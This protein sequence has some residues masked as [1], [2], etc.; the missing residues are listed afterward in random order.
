MRVLHCIPSMQRGGAQRQ[1]TYIA[2]ELV[3]VG[4]D[5]HV[6]VASD[7]P[8]LARLEAT[9][10][11]VHRLASSNH[12][13]P[14]L[15]ARLSRIVRRVRPD[16]IQVWLRQMEA[17]GGVVALANGTPFIFSERSSAGAYP[18]TLKNTVRKSMARWASAIV[19]NSAG[20]DRYWEDHAGGRVRRYTIANAVP[21][22]EIAAA[23]RADL[24]GL[25]IGPGQEVVLFA[26]R[27]EREKNLETLVAALKRVLATR[28]A[29]AVCCGEGRLR[30]RLA[31]W[32]REHDLASRVS[33]VGYVPDLWSWMKRANV[34]VSPS[35]FEGNPNVVLEAM[36]CGSPLVVSDIPAHRELVDETTALLV[37]ASSPES[38]A[39]AINRALGAPAAAAERAR[40]AHT[41]ASRCAL[42]VMTRQY[43]EMYREVLASATPARGLSSLWARRGWSLKR[44]GV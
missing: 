6:A 9:G 25:G 38:L 16:L 15:I 17:L 18:R 10:A 20:G 34:V 8:N 12:H 39:D 5:I 29:R 27:L 35:H 28:A 40:A 1:L 26:G 13:D 33:V 31:Q 7:G 14:R 21:L 4:W 22:D 44:P 3:R 37:D 42:P 2:R 24:R 41:R 36:A 30:P 11:T 19:S 32:L 23:P 43:V